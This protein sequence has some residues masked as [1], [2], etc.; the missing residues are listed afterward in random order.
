MIYDKHNYKEQKKKKSCN[1]LFVKKSIG[2]C[3]GN[4][5]IIGLYLCYLLL[6]SWLTV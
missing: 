4:K 5:I 2:V 6:Y 1:K 3:I